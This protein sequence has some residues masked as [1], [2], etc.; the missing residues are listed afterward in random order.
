M[1]DRPATQLIIV[2]DDFD[3]RD[4]LEAFFSAPEFS[5][6]SFSSGKALLESL[7]EHF[8]GV[9]VCDLKMPEM[10]GL[11]VLEAL[12]NT[13]DAPPVI[14]MT[15]FGDI[16][17]AVKAMNLGAYDFIEKPFDPAVMKEKVLQ[18]AQARRS[19]S[20]QPKLDKDLKLREY[21]DNF[22]KSLLEQALTECS[23]HV[24]KVCD[25]LK[26]PRR[27]LNEKLLKHGISR[28]RFLG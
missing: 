6:T 14:L 18:A 2:D 20:T 19:Q 11:E 23:G 1:T 4:S 22:E 27:T 28:Q 24:G 3:L 7:P 16:P 13:S 5:V 26:I 21:V 12:H 15:A 10:S 8:D 9:V 25:L 17:V